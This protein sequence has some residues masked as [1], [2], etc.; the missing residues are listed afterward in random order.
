[1]SGCASFPVTA[2]RELTTIWKPIAV[3]RRRKGHLAVIEDLVSVLQNPLVGGRRCFRRG[4]SEPGFETR[5][6][7]L[8]LFAGN[9]RPIVNLR[10]GV[11]RL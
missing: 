4:L 2:N 5:V 11:S 10:A 6:A 1:M 8:G 3:Q 7:K 9:Q